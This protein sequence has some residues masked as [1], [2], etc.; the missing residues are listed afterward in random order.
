M[1]NECGTQTSLLTPEGDTDVDAMFGPLDVPE[2]AEPP[3]QDEPLRP[4][5][6]NLLTADEAETEWLDL[7]AW[8]N[9]LRA[10]YGVPPTVMFR[11]PRRPRS[12]PCH[13]PFGND[14]R[15]IRLNLC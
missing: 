5:N 12:A 2:A 13:P 14:C 9:W 11:P 1:T 7:N 3:D 6:W 10:T 15:R 4:I 8:V